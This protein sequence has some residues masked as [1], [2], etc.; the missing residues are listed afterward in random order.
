MKQ[1]VNRYHQSDRT[2]NVGIGGDFASRLV[3]LMGFEGAISVCAENQWAGTEY[4]IRRMRK[5]LIAH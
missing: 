5:D 4:T 3:T 1:N 2:H